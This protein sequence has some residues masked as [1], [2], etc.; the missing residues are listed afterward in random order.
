MLD[1]LSALQFISNL[2]CTPLEYRQRIEKLNELSATDSLTPQSI[3]EV[4]EFFRRE[5][6]KYNKERHDRSHL[7][8][9][10]MMLMVALDGYKHLYDK[11]RERVQKMIAEEEAYARGECT[12]CGYAPCMCDQQ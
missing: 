4:T 9:A 10:L 1:L 2:S 6:W 11:D 12:T 7:A 5:S 3:A 8:S